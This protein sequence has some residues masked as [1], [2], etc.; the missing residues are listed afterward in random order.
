MKRKHPGTWREDENDILR[1]HYYDQG[2]TYCSNILGRTIRAVCCQAADLGIRRNLSREMVK[3][4]EQ[5][6]LTQYQE[7]RDMK[8]LAAILDISIGLIKRTL[9][10]HGVKRLRNLFTERIKDELIADY[11]ANQLTLQ[12]IADKH[13]ISVSY[14]SNS[15]RGWGIVNPERMTVFR[16]DINARRQ[17]KTTYQLWVDR[18][19]KD[20][21]D[22]RQEKLRARLSSRASGKN[23]NMYGKPSPQGAGNGWK[24]WYREHYFRSLR[25][26]MFMIKMDD[27]GIAWA[28][29]E[30][31]NSI[32]YTFN[33][34]E[35]TYRPDFIVGNIM[36]ELKPV[37]LHD[38]PNVVA[39]KEAAE[40][41]CLA[42]GMEY[43]LTD[44]VIVKSV[45]QVALDRGDIRFDRKYLDKFL[46]Y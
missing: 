38:T 25:E 14:V 41:Y 43:R 9:K 17:G 31:G 2:S 36:Y 29:G 32:R 40:A 15:V 5:L 28:P 8:R 16:G 10:K 30:K 34:A 33:G 21:A 12:Q 13:G 46:A 35:R 45:I 37:K 11:I 23:N 24:G 22:K 7:V 39:K 44:W 4:D 42:R 6:I 20:E 3:V 1:K 18:Y 27:E 19:G 26:V